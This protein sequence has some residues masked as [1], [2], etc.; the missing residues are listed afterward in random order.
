MFVHHGRRRLLDEGD[1]GELCLH[2]SKLGF[3]TGD[4]F[5]ETV[6]FG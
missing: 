2:G 4:F 6:A 3:D 1:A 5:T